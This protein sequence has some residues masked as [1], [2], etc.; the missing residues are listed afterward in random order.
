MYWIWCHGTRYVRSFIIGYSPEAEEFEEE[1]L[2][3]KEK[4]CRT[5]V[6][7]IFKILFH[8]L[9]SSDVS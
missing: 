8:K 4:Y 3:V 2:A 7:E 5:A 9:Y 1:V 6:M